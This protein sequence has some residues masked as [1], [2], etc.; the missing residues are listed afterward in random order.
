[1]WYDCPTCDDG[2][3]T[4]AECKGAGCEECDFAKKPKECTECNGQG[5]A[6]D[7]CGTCGGA[8]DCEHP[9]Y[10]CGTKGTDGDPFEDLR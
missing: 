2:E 6:D 4:C 10:R 9:C 7:T 3:V 5:G 8:C 1:M